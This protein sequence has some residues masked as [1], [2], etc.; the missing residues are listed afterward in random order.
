M[1][2]AVN[3]STVEQ[4]GRARNLERLPSFSRSALDIRLPSM[5]LHLQPETTLEALLAQ[6]QPWCNRLLWVVDGS[7]LCY[8]EP[9]TD[10]VF[11]HKKRRAETEEYY[12]RDSESLYCVCGREQALK[13]YPGLSTVDPPTLLSP[14]IATSNRLVER[15][16]PPPAT[17]V[18]VDRGSRHIFPNLSG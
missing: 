14:I 9:P 10:I 12:F 13:F 16:V 2:S 18:V 11:D 7:L 4:P 6:I 15:I 1:E 5:L 8:G 3:G 17:V